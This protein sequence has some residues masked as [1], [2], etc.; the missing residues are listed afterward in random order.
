[1]SKDVGEKQERYTIQAIDKALDL[2]ELLAEHDSLNL[3]ELT[4]MLDQPKSST[5]RIIL[6]LENR[7]FISRDDDNGKYC[8]GYKQLMLTRGL[9][10]R[11]KLRT[12]AMHEMKRLSELYGD[13]INLGVM[14][15]G[16]VLYVEIIEST[17]PLR[18]TDTVGSKAPFH[19]TAM[20]KAMSAFL[21]EDKVKAFITLHGLPAIT[22]NTI[23]SVDQLFAQLKVVHEQGF[24]MDDQEIVEGARCVAAPIFNMY[25]NIEGAVSISGAMHRFAPDLLP[26][27][28]ESIKFAANQISRKLGYQFT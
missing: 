14:L 6:T 16:E 20:G 15:E 27:M 22:P 28:A 3:L 17:Q 11:N 26:D 8:L 21:P 23:T 19:A 7:G 24:S 18:M 12:A 10:E 5:Y 9:L 4:E 1:M 2:L 25:G 13:T